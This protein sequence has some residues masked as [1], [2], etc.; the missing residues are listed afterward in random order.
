MPSKSSADDT[1]PDVPEEVS[2]PAPA[3]TEEP[4]GEENVA[5]Y[6]T[7]D[8]HVIRLDD[9]SDEYRA[10]LAEEGLI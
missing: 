2:E 8:G 7:P 9:S 10:K 4:E 6:R 5:W 3:A 1:T